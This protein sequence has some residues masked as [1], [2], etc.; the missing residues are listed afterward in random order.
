MT[1]K[2]FL[3]PLLFLVATIQLGA[4]QGQTTDEMGNKERVLLKHEWIE[5][6][7]NTRRME[8]IIQLDLVGPVEQRAGDSQ[9]SH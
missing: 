3:I 9:V 7:P 5:M 6:H 2:S 4:V 8:P 1:S